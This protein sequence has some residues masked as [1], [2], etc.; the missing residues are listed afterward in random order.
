[1]TTELLWNQLLKLFYSKQGAALQIPTCLS[2]ARVSCCVYGV[3]AATPISFA[4]ARPESVARQRCLVPRDRPPSPL[5]KFLNKI[6]KDSLSVLHLHFYFALSFS[7]Q[8]VLSLVIYL[9]LASAAC[10]KFYSTYK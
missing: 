5:Q 3:T 9:L 10:S 8:L 7:V 2:L 1:M 4:T 6:R